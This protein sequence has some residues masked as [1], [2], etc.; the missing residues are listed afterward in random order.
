MTSAEARQ[1]LGL[2][3]Q[4]FAELMGGG[5]STVQHWEQTGKGHRDP[6]PQAQ[7][8][9]MLLVG[10]YENFPDAYRWWVSR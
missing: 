3:Q 7:E 8:L 4:A 1:K 2:S 9:M 6:S 10:L 5:L